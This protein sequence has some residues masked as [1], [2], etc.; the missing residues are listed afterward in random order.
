MS[1]RYLALSLVTAFVLLISAC[2]PQVAATQAPATEPPTSPAT[3]A[4][5]EA[6]TEPPAPAEPK[7]LRLSGGASDYGTIDPSLATQSAEIQIAETTSLGVVRQNETTAEIELAMATDYAVSDD[8][9]TYTVH[10]MSGVPWV[11]YNADSGQVEVVKDCQG[12]DRT[13]T[14]Q[15]FAYGIVR[16][17]DPATASDYAYALLPYLAGADDFNSGKNT[18]PNSVGVKAVNDTTIQYTFTAPAVYNLN[19]L[20]LWIAHAE[21]K[22][23]IAGDDCTQAAGDRWT[24]QE[25]FQ[26]YGPFTLKEWVH[27]ASMALIKNPFWPGNETVPQAKIDEIQIRFLDTSPALSEFEA[28]N[29]DQ[30]AIPSE[31]WDR[32]HS[33]PTYADMIRPYYTLGTE[34]YGFNTKLAPTDDQRVRL[35]LSLAIDRDL[36]VKQVVKGGIPAQFFTNP[37]AA[38]GPKPELYP[39]GGVKYNPD[40][41]KELL[42][43]YLTEKNIKPEKLKLTL[44]ANSTEGN[45]KTGEAIVGMW[46]DVLGLDV[47]FVTQERQVYL[48]TRKDGKENIYRNSWVQDYPDANNFLSDVFGLNAAFTAVVDWPIKVG[49]NSAEE[50]KPGS[51]PNF[52]K[53]SDLLKQA[54]NEQDTK[55]RMDLYAQAEQILLVD[56]AV[57]APL[58]WYSDDYLMRPEIKD[59]KSITGY[60]HYEKW[61]IQR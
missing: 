10:I 24:E 13:V 60:D 35:A 19:L 52:D 6:P 38:G 7:I 51:N 46:K 30:T 28:G 31:E 54:A 12:K 56:E 8:G 53:F 17:I 11:H 27:D 49:S 23:L 57:V 48:V 33:D 14:A 26:G 20:G 37:G 41:A 40:K 59:T 1:K 50:Y 44:M 25:F 47:N 61:D 29:L 42:N 32:I 9:L 39:D 3:V 21:P 55:K 5:T 15:D 58:Y 2:A 45:Q 18:D 4:P 22:W 43:E 34:W 36:L 16:T